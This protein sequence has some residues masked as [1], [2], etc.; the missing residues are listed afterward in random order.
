MFNVLKN[1]LSKT[2]SALVKSVLDVVDSATGK[3]EIDEFELEDIEALLIKA[4]LGIEL[5][6]ETVN[7]IK[8]KKK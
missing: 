4:D 5:S 2:S 8:E 6:L 3:D 1:A 7:K